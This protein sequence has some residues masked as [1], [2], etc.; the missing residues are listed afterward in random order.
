MDITSELL[1]LVAESGIKDGVCFL[2]VPHTTAGITLNENCDPA[3]TQDIEAAL[4]KL[5]PYLDD[6]LH[7]EGN[8][9]AH[10]KATLVGSTLTL[11]IKKGVLAL[12]RWQGVYFCEFDG[13]RKRQ[14]LV[15]LAGLS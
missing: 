8:S 5:V 7:K 10:I 2:S 12:G 1:Q 14:V 4:S 6:Y 15:R 11:L 9:A 13:P 3:V